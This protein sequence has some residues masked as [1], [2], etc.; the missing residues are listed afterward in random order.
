MPL[1]DKQKNSDQQANS[2]REEFMYSVCPTCK[3]KVNIFA[4]SCPKCGNRTAKNAYTGEWVTQVVYGS[5]DPKDYIYSIMLNDFKRCPGCHITQ[6]GKP[7]KYVY[8]F[9]TSKGI[10]QGN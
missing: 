5:K 1:K 4:Y 6:A 9:A 2:D 7:C 3:E 10:E 8:C